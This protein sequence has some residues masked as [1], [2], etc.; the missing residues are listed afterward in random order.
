MTSLLAWVN[1]VEVWLLIMARVTGW[2]MTAPV[3]SSRIVSM[4]VQLGFAG[5]LSIV[6]GETVIPVQG[7]SVAGLTLGPYLFEVVKQWLIGATIGFVGSV[8]FTAAEMAGQLIDMQMGFSMVSLFNP[9]FGTGGALLANWQAWLAT[10]VF[11]TVDGHLA[12]LAGLLHSFD[13][14]PL[15]AA[16]P[17]GPAAEVI[18]RGVAVLFV[19]G[20]Q[21]SAPMLLSLLLF[22]VIL[23]FVSRA[24][25]QVNVLF[26]ALPGKILAGW[27]IALVTLPVLILG[28]GRVIG[29]M[30]TAVDGVLRALGSG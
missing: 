21:L 18:A 23:A 13:W 25:P 17:V 10:L 15:G 14:I 6:A 20:I 29:W 19:L 9:Q 8:I 24:A 26:V 1:Q 30:N 5:V 28:I 16:A 3:F 22:D 2:V 27:G 7:G 11:V 12:L 4:P